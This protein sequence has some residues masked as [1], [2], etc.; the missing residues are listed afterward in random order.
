VRFFWVGRL[1]ASEC[2][3]AFF[4][5]SSDHDPRGR[6]SEGLLCTTGLSE[7]HATNLVNS[8]KIVPSDHGGSKH[9]EPQLGLTSVIKRSTLRN[10]NGGISRNVLLI[11][12]LKKKG[13]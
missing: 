13:P 9:E 3:I 7:S 10:G 12:R 8:V 11:R 1:F 4:T 5:I 2:R 6:I